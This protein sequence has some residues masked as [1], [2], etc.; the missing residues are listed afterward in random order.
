[1]VQKST[2][3]VGSS[4]KGKY[5]NLGN[6][7]GNP[8]VSRSSYNNIGKE[9]ELRLDKAA[10]KL[11]KYDQCG[12]T[13]H[14]RSGCFKIIGYPDWFKD[15]KD[16]RNSN[17]GRITAHMAETPTDVALGNEKEESDDLMGMMNN[18]RRMEME[19]NRMIKGKGSEAELINYAYFLD[20]AASRLSDENHMASHRSQ[21]QM[22]E[23]KVF[24]SVGGSRLFPFKNR[25]KFAVRTWPSLEKLSPTH[26][27]GNIE[28]EEESL[29]EDQGLEESNEDFANH[30]SDSSD[31]D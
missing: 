22:K 28:V 7:T 1:M 24:L 17:A 12:M 8:S 10:K 20:F 29:S 3:N 27:S 2:Y 14:L 23:K 16:Q 4:L 18:I 13:G 30:W 5:T 9:N 19:L 25:R 15:L 26:S 11:L 21:H 31:E 6:Q